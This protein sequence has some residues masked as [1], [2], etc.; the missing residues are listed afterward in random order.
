MR[1]LRLLAF[2]VIALHAQ[3]IQVKSLYQPTP[4]DGIWKYHVGDN[5]DFAA[6][7]F[8]DSSWADLAVPGAPPIA[9]GA[10]W[11]RFRVELPDPLPAEPLSILIA[12]I[13]P[14][15][16]I[17]VN[18]HR[19]GTF[20]EPRAGHSW[21][22]WIPDLAVFPLPTGQ[23]RLTVAIRNW[24]E[25]RATAGALYN[26]SLHSWLATTGAIEGKAREIEFERRWGGAGQLMMLAATCTAA[27]FF[28]MIPLWRRDAPEY[29]WCGWVLLL[30]V[31]MR[32]FQA[33]PWIVRQRSL[34]LIYILTFLAAFPYFLSWSRLFTT[35]FARSLSRPAKT[36][37]WL[38]L[39]AT[40][41]MTL[42]ATFH[43][44]RLGSFMPF[45]SIL[46]LVMMTWVYLDLVRH[47]RGGS[48]TALMH[49]AVSVFIGG[50]LVYFALQILRW[51]GLG[52]WQEGLLW[53]QIQ[54]YALDLRAVGMLL[55]ALSMAIVLNRRSARLLDERTRLKQELAAAAE[56]QALLL[57]AESVRVPGFVTEV[58]YLPASEV[59]GDFHYALRDGDALVVLIGDVSGKGLRAAMLVAVV[60]GI[61]RDTAERRPAAILT[62]LNQALAGQTRGGFVTCC[63]A[64]FHPDGTTTVANA[65]HLAPYA[66]GREVDV[67]AGL[68]LGL[69]TGIAYP[70]TIVRGSSV[71]FLSDG[72]VEAEDPQRELFGFHRACDLSTH[73]AT[74]IADAARAWGQNDDITVVT[75]RRNT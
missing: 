33:A 66:D 56:T 17:F 32:I 25:S 16:E 10:V 28:L 40:V 19:I 73:S 46:F 69:V 24:E 22:Q 70:E 50:N 44:S 43:W 27:V 45:Y 15:Y 3:P 42:I 48:E 31:A 12:P 60:I 51:T 8:D 75:V 1:L 21:G 20:G 29:F 18:G 62:A 53:R 14:A 26:F 49:L 74:G 2:T 23:R 57:P 5:P 52:A 11:Y 65:G 68:P 55:F 39:A 7:D 67:E 37:V 63:C 38:L 47:A 6:P 30:G 35:L 72:V 64:R 61:L 9:A 58:A 41:A 13:S 4:L 34:V 71:T 59:G 36:L 54:A